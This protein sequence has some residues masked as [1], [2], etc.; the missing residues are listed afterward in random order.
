MWR[1]QP[2]Q[3][4]VSL[5]DWKK[6][7]EELHSFLDYPIEINILGG[8]PLLKGYIYE[9]IGFIRANNFRASMATNGFLINKET[10]DRIAKSGLN[11]LGVSLDSLDEETHD[12][13][14]GVNGV[15]RKATAAID[16]IYNCKSEC[17]MDILTIIM[18]KNLDDIVKLAD[19]VNSDERIASI[20]FMAIMKPH[21]SDLDSFWYKN[22]EYSFLWPSDTQETTERINQL[23]A[24]KKQGN[25]IT[26]P[27]EQLERFRLYFQDPTLFVRPDRCN[28]DEAVLNVSSNGNVHLCWDMEPIGNIKTSSIK[29]IWDSDKAMEIRQRIKG[30]KKNCEPMINCYYGD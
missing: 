10:A 27:V 29:E 21:C 16:L 25:K 19:W 11:T 20:N 4:D 14:R 17:K 1:V 12:Y 7:I 28:F 8:E 18:G 24:R 13:L 23:I 5:E 15:Y 22:N 30:C 3:N 9:L 6:F 26:N 2:E